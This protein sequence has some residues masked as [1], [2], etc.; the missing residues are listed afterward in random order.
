[1]NSEKEQKGLQYVEFWQTIGGV[2]MLIR[3]PT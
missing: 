2:K 3:M 1:M